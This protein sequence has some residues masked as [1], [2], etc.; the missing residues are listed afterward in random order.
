MF[1]SFR[2]FLSH[3]ILQVGHWLGL[4]HTFQG[5]CSG[6]DD[7]DDTPAENTPAGGCPVGRDTCAADGLDP[8]HNFMDYTV[9]TNFARA[10]KLVLTFLLLTIATCAFFTV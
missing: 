1:H 7:V 5:G 8:I 4:L 9:R 3:S 10:D 6:G 2:H